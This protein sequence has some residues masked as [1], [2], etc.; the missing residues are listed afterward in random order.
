MAQL[1]AIIQELPEANPAATLIGLGSLLLLF[2]LKR[3]AP[4]LPGALITVAV[5]I[6]VV[7]VFNLAGVV[8]VVGEV[9]ADFAGFGLPGA[10]FEAIRAMLPGALAIVL[11]GY[12]ESLGGARAAAEK[13][14]EEIDPNQ[15]ILLDA[16]QPESARGRPRGLAPTTTPVCDLALRH[17]M[18]NGGNVFHP[19][20]FFRS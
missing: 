11:V 18:R 9:E 8:D 7:S 20:L 13:A 14:G 2:A 16:L 5:A 17:T 19:Y 6:A 15:Q 1:W 10:P 12:A 4:R 3:F